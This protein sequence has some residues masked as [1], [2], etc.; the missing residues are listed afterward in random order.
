[1]VCLFRFLSAL[2]LD[3]ARADRRHLTCV[4]RVLYTVFTESDKTVPGCSWCS[5]PSVGYSHDTTSPEG[6]LSF[7]F[8]QVDH[9]EGDLLLEDVKPLPP[10]PLIALENPVAEYIDGLK[11]SV[12]FRIIMADVEGHRGVRP[13]LKLI[14]D[15]GVELMNLRLALRAVDDEVDLY[16]CLI[17]R[18]LFSKESWQCSYRPAPCCPRAG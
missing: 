13:R 3:G 4:T 10:F 8:C 16:G 2:I 12:L 14:P 5:H 7:L 11:A 18:N 6:A 1:M 17:E 9:P 15:I